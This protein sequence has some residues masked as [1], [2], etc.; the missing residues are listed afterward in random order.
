MSTRPVVVL[1]Q[2]P[3]DPAYTV[4]MASN[5]GRNPKCMCDDRKCTEECMMRW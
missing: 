1:S 4:K 3:S 5:P 2:L